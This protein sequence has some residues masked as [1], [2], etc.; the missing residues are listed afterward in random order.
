M[1]FSAVCRRIGTELTE[2]EEE[3]YCLFMLTGDSMA[4]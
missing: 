1:K 2:E 3:D 4:E